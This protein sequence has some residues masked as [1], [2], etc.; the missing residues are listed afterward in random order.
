MKQR[1][2][3]LTLQELTMNCAYLFPS[4][5]YR[6]KNL[7]DIVTWHTQG[8]RKEKKDSGLTAESDSTQKPQSMVCGI[9]IKFL[10]EQC[11]KGFSETISAFVSF[12]S[13]EPRKS[14]VHTSQS[15]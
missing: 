11:L 5:M 12:Q 13:R 8:N 9:D 6:G 2:Y 10:L 1:H 7:Y 14:R 15:T 4:A 3:S